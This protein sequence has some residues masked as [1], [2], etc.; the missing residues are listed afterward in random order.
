MKEKGK[1]II[2]SKKVQFF[3]LAAA[4]IPSDY[5]EKQGFYSRAASIQ[6]RLLFKSGVYSRA[7]LNL[8]LMGRIIYSR[9]HKGL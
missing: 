7:L 1:K 4:S 2:Y 5:K 8:Y 3:L 9:E 6:E